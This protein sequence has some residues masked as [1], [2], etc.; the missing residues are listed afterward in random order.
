LGHYIAFYVRSWLGQQTEKQN[1][2]SLLQI[3]YKAYDLYNEISIFGNEISNPLSKLIVL[4]KVIGKNKNKKLPNQSHIWTF[5]LVCNSIKFLSISSFPNKS[6][7]IL[8]TLSYVQLDFYIY[9]LTQ[10]LRGFLK[11]V[12]VFTPSHCFE[13]NKTVQF[14]QASQQIT[15]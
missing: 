2:I 11:K 12:Y 3:R 1:I 15:A 8:F 6:Y 13:I 4:G 10:V 7:F 5:L 14:F 9:I